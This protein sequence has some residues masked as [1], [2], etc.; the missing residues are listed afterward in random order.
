M[1]ILHNAR[2]YSLGDPSTASAL[3]VDRG[4]IVALGDDREILTQFGQGARTFDL[5]QHPV[6][7][8]LIDAHVHL[9]HYSLSLQKIDCE[10]PSLAE[11]LRLVA[12]R[13]KTTPPGDWVLGHGWNQ[14]LWPEGFPSKAELD[15]IAPN[16]PVYLTHKSLHTGWANS[17]ALRAA[18]INS[19]TPDPSDGEIQRE[20]HGN[21][22]GIL[23][24][25]AMWMVYEAI[26]ELDGDEL[27]EALNYA[28]T[29]LWEQGLTGIHDFDGAACFDALQRLWQNDKLRLRV[30]K[31]IP[32]A[33]L[34]HA[35][36]L[37]L[38][39]GFGDD[40]LRIGG[41]KAFADGALG[42]HT[43]AM[44]Q[45]YEN[46]PENRGMLLLDAEE[47]LEHG[48]EA[49]SA[50]LS[51]TV[52]AIGD[53]ANHEVLNAFE[54]LRGFEK[55]LKD[56]ES[57]KVL[58]HRIEHVQLLHPDDAPRLAELGIIASMQP[59]HATSDMVMAD[60]YWGERA[61]HSYAW[62]SQ[63]DHGAVLAF[64]SDAP[65]EAPN[66]FWGLHA[67]VTRQRADG[68]P[69]SEGW[70]PQQR[71]N[72]DESLKAYTYGAAY[73]AGTE[74]IQGKLAPGFWADL[75]VLNMDPFTCSPEELKDIK[76][77]G[78]MVTGEW[79]YE[80]F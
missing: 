58:R 69:G 70:Y 1:L 33:D 36:A 59:I 55:T 41:I 12:E 48:Q 60:Q 47:I 80:S 3:A 51:M 26:P 66:P 5:D 16:N 17:A 6:I 53:K 76:S 65:V 7:P 20:E 15:K 42:P 35:S 18:G 22:T 40:F 4:K 34:P 77:L 30:V 62:R 79:V 68:F 38:R 10:V 37:G 24:E 43:A 61:G 74:E 63:L 78:T 32:V 13:A 9:E 75:V 21:P 54:R 73:A 52:H 67:A 31:N 28:Q 39:S 46:E 11:C 57:H 25:G 19:N 71:L 50:G 14:N 49:A 23:L 45:P 27:A 8:G 44:L 72:I 29:K 64:G 2:I 56:F